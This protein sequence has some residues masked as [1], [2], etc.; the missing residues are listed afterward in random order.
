M[1]HGEALAALA[2][3]RHGKFATATTFNDE[4]VSKKA[5][6]ANQSVTSA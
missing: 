5:M 2:L 1:V 4:K 3:A 6:S